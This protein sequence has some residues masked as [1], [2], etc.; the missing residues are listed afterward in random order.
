MSAEPTIAPSHTPRSASTCSFDLIPNPAHTGA[1]PRF[2]SERR[3]S[4]GSAF[5]AFAP[6]VTPVVV[7]A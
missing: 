2:P 4:I 1:S 3:Y 6:P 7:T 5:D